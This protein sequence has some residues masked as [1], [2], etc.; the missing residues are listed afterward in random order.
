MFK[1]GIALRLEFE[2]HWDKGYWLSRHLF[3]MCRNLS[4]ATEMLQVL[5]FIWI[6]LFIDGMLASS[7][8]RKSVRPLFVRHPS[9]VLY[10]CLQSIRQSCPCTQ[11]SAVH[12]PVVH[13]EVIYGANEKTDGR[14]DGRTDEQTPGQDIIQ[15][16]Q[17]QISLIYMSLP[18]MRITGMA[19]KPPGSNK[20]QRTEM[21]DDDD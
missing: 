2:S 8:V 6:L 12:L 9:V 19:N 21:T 3:W 4:Q 14:T 16:S 11:A 15:L 7:T 17:I 13:P 18:Q 5:I 10:V 1:C 20:E